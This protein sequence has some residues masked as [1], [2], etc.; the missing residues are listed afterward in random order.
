MAQFCE[1]L[2]VMVTML[3]SVSVDLSV[4]CSGSLMTDDVTFGHRHFGIW[5]RPL[6]TVE[7]VGFTYRTKFYRWNEISKVKSYDSCF[8]KFLF[9]STR[10]TTVILN[11]GN[12]FHINGRTLEKQR[13]KPNIVFPYYVSDAYEELMLLMSNRGGI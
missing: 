3:L 11:D 12:E 8:W 9:G 5:F 13:V 6:L 2:T 10:Q 1:K 4:N 7:L